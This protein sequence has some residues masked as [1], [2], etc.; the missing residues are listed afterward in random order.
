MMMVLD[1]AVKQFWLFLV[2]LSKQ[3]WRWESNQLLHFWRLFSHKIERSTF[4]CVTDNKFSSKAY[5]NKSTLKVINKDVFDNELQLLLLSYQWYFMGGII[6]YHLLPIWTNGYLW[7]DGLGRWY[8]CRNHGYIRRNGLG[9][10]LIS[11]NMQSWLYP[12]WWILALL[13]PTTRC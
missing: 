5:I 6:F 8:G 3:R 13:H 10:V 7:R 4:C 11:C 1:I 9:V 12:W 2:F